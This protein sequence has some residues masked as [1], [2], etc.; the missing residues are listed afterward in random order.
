MKVFSVLFFLFF[1]A[2]SSS[3]FAELYHV[4]QKSYA[5]PIF[6]QIAQMN[7][8]ILEVRCLDQDHNGYILIIYN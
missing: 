4:V 2:V 7:K 3:C 8:K 5:N 1:L 6:L